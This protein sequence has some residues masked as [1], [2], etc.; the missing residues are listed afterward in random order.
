MALQPE[1]R[2]FTLQNYSENIK[3]FQLLVLIADAD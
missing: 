2:I 3:T 1:D